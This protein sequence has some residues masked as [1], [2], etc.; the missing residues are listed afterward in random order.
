MQPEYQT[1]EPDYTPKPEDNLKASISLNLDQTLAVS[2]ARVVKGSRSFTVVDSENGKTYEVSIR[3]KIP[4]PGD[5]G[6]MY[7]KA[8]PAGERCDCCNGSGVK[9]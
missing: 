2:L 6:V 9:D 1:S 8:G 4:T 5:L 7:M 3:V